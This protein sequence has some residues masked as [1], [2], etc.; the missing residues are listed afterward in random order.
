MW[1]VLG[2]GPQRHG[3]AGERIGPLLQKRQNVLAGRARDLEEYQ[4]NRAAGED[5]CE[6]VRASLRVG[7]G[8]QRRLRSN[9]QLWKYAFR[10]GRRSFYQGRSGR[11]LQ[12]LLRRD[13]R[14]FQAVARL[15]SGV[16][17]ELAQA[18]LAP[19]GVFPLGSVVFDT[20]L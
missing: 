16:S 12:D 13:N 2:N 18:E 15:R 14:I 5:V 4:Q 10:H 11:S 3:P 8:E 20:V 1:R 7:Q 17:L 6:R 19:G 9:A